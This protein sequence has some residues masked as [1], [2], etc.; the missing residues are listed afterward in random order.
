MAKFVVVAVV[1]LAA[2][3][4]VA[5][6]QGEA[7][8]QRLRDMQCRQEVQE[9]PLD[10]CRQVLD[11]QLTGSMRYRFAPFRWSTGMRMQCC[12]QLQDVSREC[13]CSAIRR[14]VRGYEQTMPPL[15]EGYYGESTGYYGYGEMAGR[16]QQ[17][18]GGYY[19]KGCRCGQ[20][21]EEYGESCQ[22]RRGTG[23]PHRAGTGQQI[24][25]VRLSK[26]RQYAAGLPRMCL[27][28]PQ[29]CSVFSAG[30]YY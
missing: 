16:Q 1:C 27:M 3:M 30:Q 22:Q 9:S 10:A 24:T 17:Q 18:G 20:T 6:G 26:V 12:Q 14:M 13:R 21:R 2:L 4:A 25:R 29:E 15:E 8:Q 19:G 11:R 5:V 23:F 28:E 7:E